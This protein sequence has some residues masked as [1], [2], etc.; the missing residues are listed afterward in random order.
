VALLAAEAVQGGDVTVANR[1]IS[2]GAT[3]PNSPMFWMERAREVRAFEEMRQQ[4]L[5]GDLAAYFVTGSLPENHLIAMR[6]L[7]TLQIEET[8]GCGAAAEFVRSPAVRRAAIMGNLHLIA[9]YFD[10]RTVNYYNSVLRAMLDLDDA[11]W[12]EEGAEGRGMFHWHM[13]AHSLAH[14]RKVNEALRAGEARAQANADA[15]VSMHELELWTNHPHTC[16]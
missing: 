8:Q 6:R 11:W 12:R 16:R 7:L 15:A 10:V 9:A 3:L 5:E 4:S 14:R 1:I 2:V 13:I